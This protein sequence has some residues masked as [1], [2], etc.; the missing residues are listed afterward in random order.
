MKDT[1]EKRVNIVAAHHIRCTWLI[2]RD[3][4]NGEDGKKRPRLKAY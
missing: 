3:Y 1:V 2:L 4:N